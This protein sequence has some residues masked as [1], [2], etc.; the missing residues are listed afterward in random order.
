MG[1]II[2]KKGDITAEGTD[3][4][5][6]A[7]NTALAGGGG[8]DGAIHR[9][10]GPSVMKECVKI[11]HCPTGEAVIT[12]AGALKARKIIH[13]PGPVWRGGKNGESGLLRSSYS[14]SFALA[15]REGMRSIAFPCISTG[16]YGYPIEEAARIALEEGLSNREKFERVVYVCFSDRDLSVY[17]KVFRELVK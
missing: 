17:E 16:V 1:E 13:T 12:G 4:I 6:N 7:A 5:V 10:A 2:I 14:K 15:L 9:A 3:A 8:V 11:G